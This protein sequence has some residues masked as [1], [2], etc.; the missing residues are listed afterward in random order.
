[1]EGMRNAQKKVGKLQRKNNLGDV[2]L[3]GRI[4]LKFILRRCERVG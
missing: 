2:D 4:I 1:M 3:C